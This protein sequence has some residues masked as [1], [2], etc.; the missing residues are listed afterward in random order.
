MFKKEDNVICKSIVLVLA[1]FKFNTFVSKFK[2]CAAQTSE[3]WYVKNT[4]EEID[5][6]PWLTNENP[7]HFLWP[8]TDI[9]DWDRTTSGK[10][11]VGK[12][13]MSWNI[14]GCECNYG[15]IY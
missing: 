6:L 13:L 5:T 14:G 3:Y 12:V 9:F 10:E 11:N 15:G 1:K 7:M 4:L 2:N 8:T